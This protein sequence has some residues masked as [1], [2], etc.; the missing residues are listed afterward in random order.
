[1]PSWYHRGLVFWERVS[2]SV[3]NTGAGDALWN[4]IKIHR[5]QASMATRREFVSRY[6]SRFVARNLA[7]TSICSW[8]LD[9]SI[10]KAGQYS[11]SA[12]S[13]S[14]CCWASF[15]RCLHHLR[16]QKVGFG[17]A[18]VYPLSSIVGAV[19]D[20]I[21]QKAANMRRH[22][23]LQSGPFFSVAVRKFSLL[24]SS[25]LFRLCAISCTR[26]RTT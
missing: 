6:V 4:R 20:L 25:E 10:Y 12:S 5:K 19:H 8:V 7:R 13:A 26:Y 22:T 3:V 14:L 18:Q 11:Q 23:L 17:N 1:M 2:R 15:L 9:R 24:I 21:D 16:V